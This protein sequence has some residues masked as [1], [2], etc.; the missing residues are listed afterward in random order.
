MQ[1]LGNFKSH[2]M[3]DLSENMPTPPSST[4][5]ETTRITT[6]PEV[7]PTPP[8][9]EKR[10][11]IEDKRRSKAA[12]RRKSLRLALFGNKISPDE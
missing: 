1:S 3:V 6:I 5:G 8:D 4:S 9:D 7:P 10:V 12:S 2:S 11:Q